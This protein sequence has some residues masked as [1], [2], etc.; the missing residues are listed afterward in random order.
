MIILYVFIENGKHTV[1][2]PATDFR[3]DDAPPLVKIRDGNEPDFLAKTSM[4]GD[5][6]QIPFDGWIS[7]HSAS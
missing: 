4:F 1:H 6:L 3:T 7:T 5:H 2:E